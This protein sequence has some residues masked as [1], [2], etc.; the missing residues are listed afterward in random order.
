M[1][2]YGPGQ[3][4]IIK[5]LGLL[6][7]RHGRFQNLAKDEKSALCGRCAAIYGTDLELAD[8][9][10]RRMAAT[11]LAFDEVFTDLPMVGLYGLVDALPNETPL[12]AQVRL[13]QCL[14]SGEDPGRILS[15]L[16][17]YCRQLLRFQG[18][19]EQG[20]PAAQAFTKLA[21][22]FPAQ[23]KISAGAR[24]FKPD[25]LIEFLMSSPDTERALR[26]S[27]RSADSLRVEFSKLFS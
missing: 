9:H 15:A 10:L 12:G 3:A 22:P 4:E 20:C 7:S 6:L 8:D 27:Y 1:L 24:R 16:G 13:E 5:V 18:L 23:A 2:C 14:Q 25:K 19:T 17:S 26:Q 11:G 21:I